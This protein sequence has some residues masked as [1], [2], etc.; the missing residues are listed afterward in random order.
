MAIANSRSTTLYRGEKW[1]K[2]KSQKWNENEKW[3][4]NP[5]TLIQS[6][7]IGEK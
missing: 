6:C 1:R 7:K 4:W 2:T 3:K 5:G